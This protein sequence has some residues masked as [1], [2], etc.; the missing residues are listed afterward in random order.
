MLLSSL[1]HR[2]QSNTLNSEQYNTVTFELKKKSKR[3]MQI[4]ECLFNFH[5]FYLN[6]TKY[7]VKYKSKYT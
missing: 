6:K 4:L 5:N 3:I 2:L 7:T 1:R